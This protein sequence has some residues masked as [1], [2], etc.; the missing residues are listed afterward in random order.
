LP[1]TIAGVPNAGDRFEHPQRIATQLLLLGRNP[2]TGRLRHV[3]V[4]DIGLRAALFCDLVLAGRMVSRDGAPF[5]FGV[6]DTGDHV[7]DTVAHA[8]SARQ[9]VQWWRWYRH[10]RTDRL[11][12]VRELVDCGRWSERG[13][14][15]IRRYDDAEELAPQALALHLRG[16]V[17]AA[18][19]RDAREGVLAALTVMCGTNGRPDPRALRSELKPLLDRIVDTGEPNADHVPRV[20][21]GAT[22]FMRRP[23][24]R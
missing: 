11:E 13:S 15:P 17:A 21:A 2:V 24:R 1:G 14:G 4:L 23:T 10:V 5:A 16:V 6:T 22:V 12:L 20:L 7:L 19:I 8:V 3:R 9:N 18:Q